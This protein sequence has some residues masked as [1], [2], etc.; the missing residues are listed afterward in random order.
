MADDRRRVRD[1]RDAFA[2]RVST[3]IWLETPSTENPYLVESSYCHG[4]ALTELMHERSFADCLFLLF[5]GEL[6]TRSQA[7]LLEC[8]MIAFINPG[9]RHPAT[10]AAQAAGVGK[11]DG[12]HILPIA[13]SVLGGRHEDAGVLEP[14]M[15]FLRQ[16][17]RLEPEAVAERFDAENAGHAESPTPGFGSRFGGIDRQTAR[18][19]DQLAELPGAGPA[20][21]W[22]QGFACSIA[23][24]GAGWLPVGLAAAALSDLGFKPRAA[25]GLYQWLCAPGLLAH[26]MEMANKPLTAMPFLDDEHYIIE[27]PTGDCP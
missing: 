11:T 22:G 14:A 1:R 23:S 17:S 9:P 7:G 20:L 2:Q 16:A 19:A 21:I 24:K 18:I 3:R 5:T 13:L 25:G 15:R 8:L 10:R 6:P 4:Y 27:P 26:G 12:L